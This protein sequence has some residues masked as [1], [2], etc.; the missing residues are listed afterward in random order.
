MLYNHNN[1]KV[2]SITGFHRSGKTTVALAIINGLK[3]RGY[4]V[5]SIKDIHNEKFTME[6]IG[7]NSWKH[8]QANQES[9]FA[10]SENET[11][12]IWNRQ[13]SL[14]E[15]LAQIDADFVVIE[16][17][18]EVAVPRIICAESEKQIEELFDETV[19]AVSGIIANTLKEY[20]G[21]QVL[22]PERDI[23]ELIHLVEQKVFP[24][25][26]QAEAECCSECGFSCQEMVGKILTHEKTR[27]EC[28]SDCSL[29]SELFV[30]GK[31]LTL[32][33][34]VQRILESTIKGFVRN[35]KGAEKGSI[36]IRIKE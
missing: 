32:V 13:L 7:S 1:L 8:L 21:I 19:F 20:A 12:Q 36:E 31:K 18:K 35:L 16:G 10:R 4:K 24:I 33:P 2:I 3:E 15:M 14:N 34:F 9:V 26:P 27:N 29:T 17:M 25:L 23:I 28:K 5:V 22:H 11:Y 30:N 6:K